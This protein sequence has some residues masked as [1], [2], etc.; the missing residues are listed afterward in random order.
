M[1]FLEIEGNEEID[2]PESPLSPSSFDHSHKVGAL[3]L[4]RLL[5]STHNKLCLKALT[6]WKNHYSIKITPLTPPSS[7]K[8]H[9]IKIPPTSLLVQPHSSFFLLFFVF[10]AIILYY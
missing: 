2:F 8:S 4:L 3:V 9:N 5:T 1:E 10:F 7:E 6:Q